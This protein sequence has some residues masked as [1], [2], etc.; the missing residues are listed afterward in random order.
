MTNKAWPTPRVNEA[1][2]FM[3]S[4]HTSD[5]GYVMSPLARQLERELSEAVASLRAAGLPLPEQGEGKP[6]ASVPPQGLSEAAASPASPSSLISADSAPST[7][8]SATPPARLAP[9]KAPPH[10]GE[11]VTYEDGQVLFHKGD[12]A[13]HLAIIVQGAVDVF[14]P[15]DNKALATLGVGSSFGEQAVLEGGV[16]GASVRAV[17]QVKCIEIRT[18]PLRDLLRKDPGL[19]RPTVEALLLQLGMVNQITRLL[20]TPGGPTEYRIA[21]EENLSAQQLQRKLAEVHAHPDSHGLS[22]E[23]LMFLK[24]ES[25][26]KLLIS[27]YPAGRSFAASSADD[28]GDAYV[29]VAGTAEG[30]FG[31][32]VVQLGRGSI[33]GLAEAISGEMVPWR[34]T[35]LTEVTVKTMPMDKVLRDLE[36]ANP[37]LR[38]IVRYTTARILDLQKTLVG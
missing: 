38:G 13:Q 30:R 24:L 3:R 32:K 26:G 11:T 1:E 29:L 25:C 19:L 17:G 37:G 10:A 21:G 27:L 16:R 31:S 6:A 34:L 23:Q 4:E 9:S 5:Q 35:A 36:R 7:A 18:G 22:A 2:R 33:L 14:D 15:V 8:P 12:G 20:A 28:L